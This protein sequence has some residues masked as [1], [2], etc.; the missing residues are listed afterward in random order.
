M[1]IILKV[2]IW[3]WLEGS[4]RLKKLLAKLSYGS[5]AYKSKATAKPNCFGR[6][7]MM[8]FL[9]PDW[10]DLIRAIKSGERV[11]I[12]S[13][14]NWSIWTE[15]HPEYA[16]RSYKVFL[17]MIMHRHIQQ[18]RPRLGAFR[19]SF[20]YF[21]GPRS[22]RAAYCYSLRINQFENIFLRTI[23][24]KISFHKHTPRYTCW[25]LTL[26]NVN[27]TQKNNHNRAIVQPPTKTFNIST[28]TGSSVNVNFHG[29]Y[30]ADK[31]LSDQ[32]IFPIVFCALR[33]YFRFIRHLYL[34]S[35]SLSVASSSSVT[36][37][38]ASFLE[39]FLT[40]GGEGVGR[41]RVVSLSVSRVPYSSS[42]SA[43]AWRT[44]TSARSGFAPRLNCA[45]KFRNLTALLEDS[46][47]CIQ[48]TLN[49]QL[50]NIVEFPF[51]WISDYGKIP[52]Y[53]RHIEK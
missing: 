35:S 4:K 5:P 36:F 1:G 22:F 37:F 29:G 42:E 49:T 23:W 30:R 21:I 13:Y 7:V 20:A 38:F 27:W 39:D 52:H 3:S 51:F 11:E 16:D 9:R 50:E 41:T 10:Y 45:G 25:N 47:L 12:A 18:E 53:K 33:M 8:C 6:K 2:E 48:Q 40:R 44:S 34:I 32:F 28:S 17:F 26:K 14:V 46:Y 19:L 24:K 15:P 43:P 31:D